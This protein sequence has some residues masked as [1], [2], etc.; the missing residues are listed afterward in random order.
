[1]KL[2]NVL[3]L[4]EE[5]LRALRIAGLLHDVG[6][7]GVPDGILKKPGPLT[8]EERTMMQEHV[9]LSKLIV[10]GVP[11][12]QDVADA[13][14]AHHERWDGNGYP[15]GLKGEDI[16]LLGR[17][18]VVADAYS[19]MILDRPYRK[20]LSHEEA[21]AEL[22]KHASTQFDPAL[23]EPFIGMLESCRE[24]AA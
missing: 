14:H 1:M 21:V 24:A 17:I 18:L 12:L 19:A 23:V 11:N 5:P 6:K 16:P 7:I 4:S 2:G 15:R 10:Q 3:G 13:V 8:D 22:R 9:A 20:A